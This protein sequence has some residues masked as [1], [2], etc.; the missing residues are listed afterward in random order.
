V[1]IKNSTAMCRVGWSTADGDRNPRA[2]EK[3]G[4]RPGRV[5][6]GLSN[7][8]L[9]SPFA[10]SVSRVLN[11]AVYETGNRLRRSACLASARSWGRFDRLLTALM[12]PQM[13]GDYTAIRLRISELRSQFSISN[14]PSTAMQT[15]CVSKSLASGG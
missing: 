14:S 6:S 13:N 15:S 12:M 8:E 4:Q 9:L 2:L 11:T 7:D 1:T 3:P 5:E 10:S